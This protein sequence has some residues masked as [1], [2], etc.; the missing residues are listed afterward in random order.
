MD[1]SKY[2]Y[3]AD[4]I[5]RSFAD[6][7]SV[8]EEEKLSRWR[9]VSEAN[10]KIYRQI[11]SLKGLEQSRQQA[12]LFPPASPWATFR[13]QKYG[14][15]FS[16]IGK[17]VL[18]YAALLLPFGLALGWWLY[19]YEV[20]KVEITQTVA[21]A[22]PPIQHGSSKAILVLDDGS[23]L[24]LDQ[25]AAFA[26]ADATVKN[27]SES[28]VISYQKKKS[29]RKA[30]VKINRL[31][32]PNGGEYNIE[33]S[34]G[35]MVYLNA[36]SELTYPVNFVGKVREVRLKGEA[37]FKVARDEA[38]PFVVKTEGMDVRV[39]GTEFN[40]NAYEGQPYTATTL[41]T[42]VVEIEVRGHQPV[43]LQPDHQ[44]RFDRETAAVECV[45][46][47]TLPYT[48]WKDGKFVFY[49]EPLGSIT[50]RLEKW[51]DVTI[52]YS[53]EELRE[54]QIFGIVSRYEDIRQV[55]ELLKSTHMVDF[56][57]AGGKIEVI[58]Y[59]SK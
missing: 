22:L 29:D 10:E 54:L 41:V 4:L 11:V 2:I 7:L 15:T 47:N 13:K 6:A 40:L 20:Q 42:G 3:I 24:H 27:T 1:L 51:Y 32:V 18:K 44:A 53:E 16:S 39:L 59:G 43:L 21:T 12:A 50:A 8:E 56:S 33:L 48:A 23:Q 19:S 45:K 5:V 28:G 17:S 46:V 30:G 31:I 38:C 49:H 37:Y 34:D 26:I 36:G 52:V 9:K 35:T 14:R 55:L 25:Q 57:Y 58:P